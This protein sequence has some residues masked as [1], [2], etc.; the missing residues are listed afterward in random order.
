LAV[1]VARGWR[2]H[3][4]GGVRLLSAARV[5]WPLSGRLQEEKSPRAFGL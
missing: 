5:L 3:S 4:R 1:V 2:H